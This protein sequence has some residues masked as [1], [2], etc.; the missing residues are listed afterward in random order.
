A[1]SKFVIE[2]INKMIPTV[3]FV[4]FSTQEQLV[5]PCVVADYAL[6]SD[7]ANRLN[8]EFNSPFAVAFYFTSTGLGASIRSTDEF[9]S[10]SIARVFGGGGHKKA[11]GF[12]I[13]WEDLGS[14]I[15]VV[16]F[17]DRK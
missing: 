8:R 1:V 7:A 12:N 2:S 5:C 11:A 14:F 9:D 10:T 6:S 4:Q 13:K 16:E 3:T 15:Q 17:V